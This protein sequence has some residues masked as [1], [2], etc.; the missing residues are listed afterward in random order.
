MIVHTRGAPM[1]LAAALLLSTS[2]WIGLVPPAHAQPREGRERGRGAEHG[3][4][5]TPHWSYDDRYRH[6]RYYPQPGYVVHGPPPGARFV[7]FRNGRYYFH[8]GVWYLQR[9]PEFVVVRP[10]LGILLPE[11]PP[12]AAVVWM[13]GV[14]YYYA[15]DTYYVQANQGYEVV[16]P[17]EGAAYGSAPPEPSPPSA[18]PSPPAATAPASPATGSWYWCESARGYYPSVPSCPEGWRP[19]APTG[20]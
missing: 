2:A 9:G 17:P 18:P 14:P 15:N 12:G 7:P 13:G 10:P 4:Y 5:R 1:R 20:R 6:D 16:A 19:V 3:P 8:S 11:L